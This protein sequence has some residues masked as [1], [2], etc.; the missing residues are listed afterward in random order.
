MIEAPEAGEAEEALVGRVLSERYRLLSVLGRGGSSL[1]FA[2]EH[3]RTRRPCAV[4]ILHPDLIARGPALRRFRAE[5]ELAGAIVHEHVVAIVD[6]DLDGGIP[7]LVM[8]L[9]Q[10]T[11]LREVLRQ[12]GALETARA[13]KL[14]FQCCEGVRAAHAHGLVH[15]DLK[16]ENLFVALHP[17]GAESIKVLDFGVAKYLRSEESAE[18]TRS[19]TL[20]GTTRY[21]APEQLKNPAG[22]DARADLYAL[23]VIL[24]EMLAGQPAF[25]AGELHAEM[26]QVLFE[27]PAPLARLRP[28]L[29]SAL[30]AC[31]ER[32]LAR[33][34][35]ARQASVSAFR[36]ALQA[37]W[38]GGF[39]R[40]STELTPVEAG[41][42]VREQNFEE[43]RVVLSSAVPLDR[44]QEV[45]W[46]PP[47]RVR[48]APDPATLGEVLRRSWGIVMLSW[49]LIV[50]TTVA[51]LIV[52]FASCL[53]R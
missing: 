44:L 48:S 22:V 12:E 53:P 5:A 23:G 32:A 21:M 30:V 24:Y 11:T 34:P 16:P 31:V 41:V 1:V 14:I 27:K 42:F 39:V 29:P 18:Q 37:A 46:R 51:G 49:P 13:L 17:S 36:D 8:E 28:D 50:A 52:G 43:A 10:G 38:G 19:G 40:S 6:C 20:V 4:K 25:A 15:R 3:V 45:A 9:L 47:E 33:E 7:Y 26:Q 35:A 2:G